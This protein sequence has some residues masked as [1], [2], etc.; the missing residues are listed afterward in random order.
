[1]IRPAR[2]LR[3]RGA[4]E[5]RD[6]AEAL[7]EAPGDAAVVLRGQ[8][9]SLILKCPDGCG[10]TLS[11]NLD[12]RAGKAWHLDQR[13]G[14]LS[15]Y[16]SVWRDGGCRSH[17]ILWRDHIIWCHRFESGNEEPNY[18]L[19]LEDLVL[20][21][22]EAIRFKSA[23]EISQRIEEIVWDVER[24]LRRLTRAGLVEEDLRTTRRQ[25][26]LSSR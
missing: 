14:T 20:R 4:G 1:M 12:P 6:E 5:Y 3:W 8:L 2:R 15:L 16:P 25:Y 19:E 22:L 26:R 10:D 17:F 18:D 23:F 13:R 21:S 24:S 9:R 11:I 7:L